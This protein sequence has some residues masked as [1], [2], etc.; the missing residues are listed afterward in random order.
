MTFESLRL[1]EPLLHAVR[2]A[3]Y[4][5]PTPIQVKAIP[6]VLD[7]HDVL[8]SAQTGTGKTA[9]FALPIIQ[10][11]A[12]TPPK[13]RSRLGPRALVLCPT[14]ELAQ[15]IDES[16]R[17]Y[18]SH[19]ETRVAVVYGGVGKRLQARALRLGIDV[20]VA[21]PGRLLDLMQ[22]GVAGVSPVEILVLD[23]ADRMLDMGFLPDIRRILAR[24]PRDRQTL[25]FSATMPA[26]MRRLA[27]DILHKPVAVQVAPVSS[28]AATVEHWVHFVE[29]R[30]KPA[31]LAKLLRRTGHSRAL[32]FTRT[33]RGAD[34]LVRDLHRLGTLAAALHGDKAQSTRTR[35]LSEFKDARTR[36]LVATDI[37]ARGLDIDDISHVYNYDL[38]HEPETYV[39]RVGRS[40]RAEASGTAVSLCS[41]E[42]RAHLRAIE[43]LVGRPLLRASEAGREMQPTASREAH[44]AQPGHAATHRAHGPKPPAPSE[45]GHSAKHEPAAPPK[46]HKPHER[47]AHREPIVPAPAR[48]DAA[49]RASHGHHDKPAARTHGSTAEPTKPAAHTIDSLVEE[50]SHAAHARGAHARV[51]YERGT[52]PP[53]RAPGSH[54]KLAEHGTRGGGSDGAAG[55]DHRSRTQ[56][57]PVESTLESSARPTQA[58][59]SDPTAAAH[60]GFRRMRR[61]KLVRSRW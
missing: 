39:H 48:K 51:A 15:Q 54:V 53:R 61:G 5:R 26:E 47:H 46:V 7:G 30:D 24:V 33:K 34:R 23:E 6:H 4:T 17:T 50:R 57:E 49:A 10:R 21:T 12:E 18:G 13:H 56:P 60:R 41:S 31:L 55:A 14:R 22:E 1:A 38:S 11:L 35:I 27:E 28:V 2:A 36:I 44:A 16:F 29:K 20:L 3:G 8:A 32:V 59:P 25:L 43:K 52:E 37:A 9:A 19:S 40:G 42:E 45:R 58:T